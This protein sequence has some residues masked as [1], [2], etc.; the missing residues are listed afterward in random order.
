[1]RHKGSV[2]LLLFALAWPGVAK[3]KLQLHLTRI[4]LAG[5]PAAIVPVDL[6][7]DG[8]LDLAVVAVYSEWQDIGVTESTTMDDI[9]GLVE[10]MTV[11][12]SLV[13][14]RELWVFLGQAGGDYEA[15]GAPLILEP[16]VLSLTVGPAGAPLL[17][18]TD[19]GVSAVRLSPASQIELEPIFAGRPVLA[20]SRT[21]VREL[22]LVYDLDGDGD[23]DF[24]FPGSE[25]TSV[26]LWEESRFD[27]VE[28]SPLL[29]LWEEDS[30]TT[31]SRYYV[32]PEV[33]DLDGDG[34]PE[35]LYPH[36]HERWNASRIFPNLGNGRFGKALD[37]NESSETAVGDEDQ[38][39]ILEHDLV[40]IGD[41]DG[42]GIT[43]FVTQESLENDDA[44]FREEIR[45][46]KRPPFRY[47]LHRHLSDLRPVPEPFLQFEAKGY[48]FDLSSNEGDG[49]GDLRLP[50][51][52]QD[53]NGDGRLDLVAL[54]LDFSL[55]QA[56]RIMTVK[57]IN[58]G[59]D[60]HVF[61]QTGDG[62]FR[63]VPD[64]DLSGKFRLDLNDLALGRLAQFEGDFD[65]D[66]R[67][68]FFQMGR[69]KKVS[70]HR[71][72]GTCNY[73]AKAD[74]VLELD[75]PP[76]DLRQV[77]ILDLDGDGRS[78][79][80]LVQPEKNRKKAET[81]P[82]RLDLYLSGGAR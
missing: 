28:Q 6:D 26:L 8:L 36:R 52:F 23:R 10:V 76:Q 47:H 22:G 48:T 1:M 27:L 62:D 60:F 12:P 25:G 74:L 29:P 82:V 46:A 37:P 21:F 3:E 19:D 56:V 16:S 31:L 50:G 17:A 30:N 81:P 63:P 67:A 38:S 65:G 20:G 2:Y 15:S 41:L 58:L 24:L 70:I 7:E 75:E 44:G 34:L 13:D 11:V 79:V 18:L 14:H 59:L 51:G 77:R 57:S 53:L 78:D 64:L 4:P 49:D 69:G 73:P 40:Y 71:G 55:F 43:E 32:L 68:D 54:T 9:E 61:C 72:D 66:G 39:G 42:D 33:R 5:A 80:L 35:L 45:E